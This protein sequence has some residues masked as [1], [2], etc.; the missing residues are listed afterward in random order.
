MINRFRPEGEDRE[1]TPASMV[2]QLDAELNYLLETKCRT[3]SK[4]QTP[5]KDMVL[6]FIRNALKENMNH[7]NEEDLA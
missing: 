1:W 6:N 4:A 5:K 3:G 2:I 7:E